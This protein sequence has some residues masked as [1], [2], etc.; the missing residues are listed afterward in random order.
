M[1]FF[2]FF[3]FFSKMVGQENQLWLSYLS[4]TTNHSSTYL[5]R[6]TQKRPRRWE[7][8]TLPQVL[9]SLIIS[10]LA[11]C[12]TSPETK[13]FFFFFFINFMVAFCIICVLCEFIHT[14]HIFLY[15]NDSCLYSCR[16]LLF[17]FLRILIKPTL[18]SF[19]IT[20]RTCACTTTLYNTFDFDT[21]C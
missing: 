21:I 9:V 18:S 12:Y 1:V 5:L 13:V 6:A 8:Q 4:V 7:P 20:L 2:F 17:L 15:S 3:F 19:V 14:K 11:C 16:K 10:K